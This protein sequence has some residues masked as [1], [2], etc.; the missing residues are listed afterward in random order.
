M[1]ML[2]PG[3]ARNTTTKMQELKT[4]PKTPLGVAPRRKPCQQS[5]FGYVPFT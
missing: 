4:E 2:P 5:T 1:W 3:A